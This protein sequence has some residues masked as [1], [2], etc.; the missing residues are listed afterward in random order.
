MSIRFFLIGLFSFF[1]WEAHSQFVQLG[2]GA[3]LGTVAG[4]VIARN[5]Q[6][7]YQSKYAYVFPETVLG[8]M[9]HG[10]SLLSLSFYRSSGATFNGNCSLKIWL[11]NT[12]VS[13]WGADPI[14][15]K[16][17]IVFCALNKLA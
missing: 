2:D 12:S 15:F 17:E 8:N 13:D 5:N 11:N 6:A 16:R 10:D 7:N 1:S 3:F 4:P 14:S 9:E